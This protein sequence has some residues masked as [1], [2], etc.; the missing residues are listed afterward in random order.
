MD[1]PIWLIAA[2][3]LI[4]VAVIAIV[5]VRARGTDSAVVDI[6]PSRPKGLLAAGLGRILRGNLDD[7]T[8]EHLEELLLSADVGVEPTTDIVERVRSAGPSTVEE[9]RSLLSEAL[10]A[11]FLAHG[12]E[13]SLTAKPA[14]VLVIGVNG[15]GKTTT[16]AKL[17][18]RLTQEGRTVILG[19]ADTFRAAAGEQLDT[20]AKRV[21][22]DVVMGQQGGDPASVAF[23]AVSSAKAKGGDVVIVDTA[24]RLHGKKN[25]MAELQKIH[26]V[27]SA[28]AGV[29]E[30]LLV[31]DATSGQNGLAQV[32]QFGEAVPLTGI[33][34]A[35]LDGTA[36]GGIVVAVERRLGV[37]VK[38]VGLGERLE[39][40]RPFDPEVFVDDLLEES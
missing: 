9:A 1:N 19:A 13:L 17:A 38:F 4:L 33:L 37:P 34:L 3:V 22:V 30:V 39:D 35:K 20:W 26:R 16:I 36:R 27:L 12:R 25:L 24:G 11:Q 10:K 23:D 40:L 31:L 7:R 28:E 5:A 32:E 29:S 21:G 8:W 6:E 15:S 14:V 2:V 18:H